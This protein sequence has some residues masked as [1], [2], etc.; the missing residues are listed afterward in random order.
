MQGRMEKII[1]YIIESFPNIYQ[2]CNGNLNKFVMLLRKGIYP[3]EYADT[4]EKI[5]GTVLPPKKAFYSDL[6]LENITDEDYVHAQK[7]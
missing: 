5:D 2:F 7:V 4:W 3:Y 1:K 6:N